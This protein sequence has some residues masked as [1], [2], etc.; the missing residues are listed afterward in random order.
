MVTMNIS[1]QGPLSRGQQ[2]RKTLWSQAQAVHANQVYKTKTQRLEVA[3][4]QQSSRIYP[5]TYG[6]TTNDLIME[7]SRL[8][9]GLNWYGRKNT[10]MQ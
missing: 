5:R 3:L 4:F 7:T 8:M 2:E 6:S 9:T 10:I 1:G